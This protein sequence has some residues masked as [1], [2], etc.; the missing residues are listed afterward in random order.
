MAILKS[1]TCISDYSHRHAMLK[2]DRELPG[3]KVRQKSSKPDDDNESEHR[4]SPGND[5]SGQDDG[6]EVLKKEIPRGKSK[7]ANISKQ[8]MILKRRLR[9]F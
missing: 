4:K 5:C 2:L 8:P 6:Q 3:R 7:S 9:T 1:L